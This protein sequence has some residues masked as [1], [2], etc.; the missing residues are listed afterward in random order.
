MGEPILLLSLEEYRQV[1][2]GSK[3]LK[4]QD[5]LSRT[6]TVLS[7]LQ[8]I[9]HYTVHSTIHCNVDCNVYLFVNCTYYY[10]LYFTVHYGVQR[11]PSALLN[12]LPL[13]GK[14]TSLPHVHCSLY[15]AQYIVQY[16][17]QISVQYIVNE[18]L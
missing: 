11:H 15:S 8:Y 13:Y 14:L 17:E 12:R 10:T 16:S 3:G 1:L 9:A 7:P 2:L 5:L 4:W 18:A 6:L